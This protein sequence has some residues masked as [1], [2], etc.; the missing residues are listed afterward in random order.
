M[1]YFSGN[2]KYQ[3][4]Y[5]FLFK[6]LVPS[7][8][9]C[10]YNL[11]EALRLVSK[12]YYRYC[13]DGDSYDDCIEYGM[14]NS[15]SDNKFPFKFP[16]REL[17]NEL[18][19]ILSY[20]KNYDLA[21]DVVLLS[22]MLELSDKKN[23]YNPLTNRL[24]PLNSSKG[25]E[26]LK[27]LDLNCVFVNYCGRN[28]KWLPETLRKH[29]VKIT[30]DLSDVTKAELNCDTVPVCTSTRSNKEIKLSENYEI[31]SKKIA[32]IQTDEKKTKKNLL[33]QRKDK[34]L[35]RAKYAKKTMK[36]NVVTFK[37][38]MTCVDML[39]NLTPRKRIDFIKNNYKLCRSSMRSDILHMSL[40]TLI[41]LK[42]K[43][44]TT[45]VQKDS[46]KDKVSKLVKLINEAGTEMHE[47]LKYR[48]PENNLYTQDYSLDS[49]LVKEMD[50]LLIEIYGSSEAV[51]KLYIKCCR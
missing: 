40:I 5:D 18:E 17:G 11:A 43:K 45:K 16:Y 22:I 44:M 10:S 46:R 31:L 35:R 48:N 38:L 50:D 19:R 4:A 13:N 24:V 26:A 23:I 15:F 32:R 21:L 8:G 39:V 37:N 33:K 28:E 1:K 36:N 29:G 12:V 41:E 14:I 34:E 2:G 20:D 27:L 49:N 3:K 51:D 30:K 6:K 9:S 42:E 7:Q 47:K 25:K